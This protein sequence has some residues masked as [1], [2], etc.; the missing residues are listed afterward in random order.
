MSSQIVRGW[1]DRLDAVLTAEAKMAGL[2]G[3]GTM[4]GEV[5]GEFFVSRV[6]RSFLPSSLD[7][8]RGRVI[9]A[10]GNTSKQI[11]V[12]IYDPRFPKLSTEGGGSLYFVEGVIGAIEVK[13]TLDSE[14]L[15]TA[16]TNCHSVTS[17][18]PR[19]VDVNAMHR[20][21]EYLEKQQKLTANQAAEMAVC[22]V[23]P[24]TYIFSYRSKLRTKTTMNAISKWCSKIGAGRVALWLTAS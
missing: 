6:L 1:F 23:K 4:I 10:D 16:L 15:E 24:R 11:D 2:L 20:F 8:G 9:D 3:H 17:L 7:I 18:S 14:E 13:S 22:Q 12:V 19:I 21:R 5:V